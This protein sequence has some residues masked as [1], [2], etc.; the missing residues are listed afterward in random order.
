MLLN[1][2]YGRLVRREGLVYRDYCYNCF[3]Y[4]CSI[5]IPMENGSAIGS[6]SIFTVIFAHLADRQTGIRQ[7]SSIS[8]LTVRIWS[9][10]PAPGIMH[11][12]PGWHF[13][14]EP[15]IC[16][17]TVRTRGKRAFFV[18]LFLFW[19]LMHGLH[20]WSSVQEYYRIDRICCGVSN[21]WSS[22]EGRAL[23]E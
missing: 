6:I 20:S 13:P 8:F 15:W 18:L 19:S 22:P 5:V 21:H 17:V 23:K 2:I 11:G 14:S 4:H 10:W 7:S 9:M 16:I 1:L 3:L 12:Q